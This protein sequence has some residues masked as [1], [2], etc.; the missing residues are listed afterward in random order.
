[1]GFSAGG[2]SAV[3]FIVKIAAIHHNVDPS[4]AL[5]RSQRIAVPGC[6]VLPALACVAWCLDACL[7]QCHCNSDH[8]LFR[9][10]TPWHYQLTT[11]FLLQSP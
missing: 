7:G 11:T 6:I 2:V 1:V 4:V 9:L 8:H 10:L 5:C 3:G